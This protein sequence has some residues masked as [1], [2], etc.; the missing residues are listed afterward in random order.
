VQDGRRSS[1]GCVKARNR[2]KLARKRKIGTHVGM[3]SHEGNSRSAKDPMSRAKITHNPP[4]TE[5][6]DSPVAHNEFAWTA[7]AIAEFGI[8]S[9]GVFYP[10][11]GS[12]LVE[13]ASLPA[14]IDASNP[15]KW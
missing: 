8:H 13:L 9:T 11:V 5:S 1:L 10:Y 12:F 14:I 2:T 15:V 6:R 4:I 7:D 3:V